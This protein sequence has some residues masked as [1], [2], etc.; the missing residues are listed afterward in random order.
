LTCVI[1]AKCADGCAIISDT[2]MMREFE[3][4]NESK[5]HLVGKRAVLAGA[6]TTALLD[7]LAE[8]ISKSG[9]SSVTDFHK[10]VEDIENITFE[11]RSIHGTDSC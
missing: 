9:V 1:G 5:I 8:Y 10:V 2:R 11:I 4:T 7:K 3:A 6:G